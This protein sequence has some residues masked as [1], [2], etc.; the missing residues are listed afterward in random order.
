MLSLVS[1]RDVL[2]WRKSHIGSCNLARPLSWNCTVI[3]TQNLSLAW[4][5]WDRPT[6][7]PYF[8]F[9]RGKGQILVMGRLKFPL[10]VLSVTTRMMPSF[11]GCT[12]VITAVGQ[13]SGVVLSSLSRMRSPGCRFGTVLCHRWHCCRPWR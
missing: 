2:G 10:G 11:P 4:T 6:I 12:S 7:W 5:Y 1:P 9:T 13:W 3:R 8:S